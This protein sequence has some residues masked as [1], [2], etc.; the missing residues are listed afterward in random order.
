MILENSSTV[1][2][3]PSFEANASSPIIRFRYR[4]VTISDL[5]VISS[6]VTNVSFV[7]CHSKEW[8]EIGKRLA[9]F[10]KLKTLSAEHCD[11]G[12]SLCM[13]ICG[14]KSLT[15]VR[16]GWL[17]ITQKTAAYPTMESITYAEFSSWPNFISA[18][19]R[20]RPTA[21]TTLSPFM[22]STQCLDHSRQCRG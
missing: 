11:S 16:M 4:I 3:K 15:N 2:I 12:D 20:K 8:V 9:T 19:L 6:V 1:E 7:S 10:P 13:N 17:Y 18:A 21:T 22:D 14:S 5:A